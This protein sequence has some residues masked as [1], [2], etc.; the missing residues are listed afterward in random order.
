MIHMTSLVHDKKI[1]CGIRRKKQP[2]NPQLRVLTSP[3]HMLHLPCN[4]MMDIVL[5]I[6]TPFLIHHFECSMS[7]RLYTCLYLGVNLNVKQM[8]VREIQQLCDVCNIH[9]TH[10]VF[11]ISLLENNINNE[12]PSKVPVNRIKL[13]S[14]ICH[15]RRTQPNSTLVDICPICFDEKKVISLKCT[16]RMCVTCIHKWFD[17]KGETCPIC[18]CQSCI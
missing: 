5:Q 6:D 9:S 1:A 16:H 2:K 12:R 7:L 17:T 15:A 8:Y 11:Q 4:T 18:R 14:R 10:M 13:M 3:V